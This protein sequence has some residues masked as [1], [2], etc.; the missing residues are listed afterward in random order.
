MKTKKREAKAAPAKPPKPPKV[1]FDCSKCVPSYCCSYGH[2]P[3]KE[4]DIKRLAKFLNITP[5]QCKKRH[6]RQASGNFKGRELKH[7]PNVEHGSM[8]KFYTGGKC[9]VYEARPDVCRAFPNGKRCGYYDFLKFERE[10]QG[11]PK[12][13]IS[14]NHFFDAAEFPEPAK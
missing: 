4:S 9:S 7:A 5:A 3:I 6:T 14:I 13:V 10:A 8:C 1:E 2:I 11:D 12:L